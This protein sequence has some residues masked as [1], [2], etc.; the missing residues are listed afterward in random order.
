MEASQPFLIFP[1]L[2]S[3]MSILESA[4]LV[5]ARH[6]GS[7]WQLHTEAT[8]VAPLLPDHANQMHFP[9]FHFSHSFGRSHIFHTK[10]LKAQK[11]TF[12]NVRVPICRLK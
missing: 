11:A 8:P 12:M 6:G 7:S 1:A 2:A 4:G 9:Y 5:S 3:G 10:I